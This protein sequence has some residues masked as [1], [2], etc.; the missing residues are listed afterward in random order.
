MKK[1]TDS[2]IYLVQVVDLQKASKKHNYSEKPCLIVDE[3]I[4]S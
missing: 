1:H 3:L 2:E 4:R